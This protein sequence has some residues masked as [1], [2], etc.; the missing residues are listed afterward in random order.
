MV[1]DVIKNVIGISDAVSAVF[2][3]Q[4]VPTATG[5]RCTIC[6]LNHH[7]A[8]VRQALE[9]EISRIFAWKARHLAKGESEENAIRYGNEMRST[10]M[11]VQTRIVCLKQQDSYTQ[12]SI[13]SKEMRDR[14]F[15]LYRR[16]LHESF[17]HF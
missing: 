16:K 10:K 14:W 17:L 6:Q 3:F 11:G 5:A 7:T 15:F 8:Q 4:L 13:K 2:V 1:D 12:M 9:G